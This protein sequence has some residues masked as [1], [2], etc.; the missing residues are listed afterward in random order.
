MVI[1]VHPSVPSGC[2][3]LPPSKSMAHRLLIGAALAGGSSHITGLDA[4]E[5]I[6]ATC[7][8][9]SVLG[10]KLAF[11]GDAAAVQGL[12]A[13]PS[14]WR[15][16]GQADCG[17]S[18]STLRF[19]IPLFALSSRPATLYGAARLFQRPLTVYE[20]IFERQGLSFV[21]GETSVQFSGPLQAG[22]YRL[23]GNVSSQ[24]IS[25][26]LFALPLL[27]AGS[28]LFIQPPFESRDYVE[29]T[30]AAQS[31]YGV[32][33][34]WEEENT[35]CIP[36]GQHYQPART[37]AE[38]DWSQAGVPAVLGAVK[39]PLGLAGL[40]P[41]S[42][43]GDRVIL[44]ILRRCGAVVEE[45]DGVFR[46]APP[47]GPLHSPGVIDL[48][49]CPDL[50]PIL[51]TL[52]LFCEGETRIINAGRLRIKESDRIASME[53]ELQK[54]GGVL[55][56]NA[57]SITICGLQR[58]H[59]AHTEAQGDHRVVM[60]LTTAAVCAGVPLTI[61]GA[62]AVAKSWPGFFRDMHGIGIQSEA[63]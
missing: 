24:F 61:S 39:G 44:D 49:P 27:S 52:A 58:L 8:G 45:K 3:R 4:S 48:A 11:A 56:S 1:Q 53:S 38:G 37:T 41:N 20:E 63:L 31:I 14:A 54:M 59:P 36:G 47:A 5:D 21:P 35:L 22:E 57:D 25:G 9:L 55:R 30:R 32:H 46:V 10:A 13:P 26:L 12:S 28:R 15:F 19:L 60:A 51:C 17:E 29:L 2:L 33:S 62:E 40:L 34:H 50:G 7:R 23:P 43:Q 42:H 16:S 18:G 6:R